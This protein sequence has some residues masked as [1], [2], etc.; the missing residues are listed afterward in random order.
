LTSIAETQLRQLHQFWPDRGWR[1]ERFPNGYTLTRDPDSPQPAYF[2]GQT[3][4][5]AIVR[6]HW[7]AIVEFPIGNGPSVEIRRLRMVE[8]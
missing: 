1:L 8:A 4:E 5:E 2:H 3:I 6:A 7:A